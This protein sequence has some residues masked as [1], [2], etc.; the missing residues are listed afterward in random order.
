MQTTPRYLVTITTGEHRGK[1]GV[2]IHYDIEQNEYTIRIN[3][4]DTHII[5][6]WVPPHFTNIKQSHANQ[7]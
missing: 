2:V 4:S 3:V 5:W 6:V 7:L 1:Q